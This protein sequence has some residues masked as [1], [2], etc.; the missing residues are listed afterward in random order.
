LL[1]GIDTLLA[2]NENESSSKW[3]RIFRWAAILPAAMGGSYVV[4]VVYRAFFHLNV[5][6]DADVNTDSVIMA[7]GKDTSSGLVIGIAVVYIAVRVAPNHE[8]TVGVVSAA[9]TL[10]ASGF[11]M[12]GTIIGQDWTLLAGTITLA[13]GASFTAL[14]TYSKAHRK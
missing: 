4:G 14:Y 3:M 13:V 6:V 9:L 10:V 1:S 2:V 8:K 11:L 7:F 12:A 5:W